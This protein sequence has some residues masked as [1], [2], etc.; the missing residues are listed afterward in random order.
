[1]SFHGLSLLDY[2]PILELGL[3]NPLVEVKVPNCHLFVGQWKGLTETE[4]N[5]QTSSPVAM[6]P[7]AHIGSDIIALI[8]TR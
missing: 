2:R 6:L 7:V 8:M 1:M 4:R 5:A 3:P